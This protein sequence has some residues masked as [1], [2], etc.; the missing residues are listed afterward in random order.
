MRYAFIAKESFIKSE[1][2]SKFLFSV[3]I[4]PIEIIRL[5]NF[6]IKP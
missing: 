2:N 1:E 4:K 3:T 6:K 5:K